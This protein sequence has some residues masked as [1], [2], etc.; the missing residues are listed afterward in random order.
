M[1]LMVCVVQ[2]SMVVQFQGALQD[3]WNRYA[4]HNTSFMPLSLSQGLK[5]PL[6]FSLPSHTL[7][8]VT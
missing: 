4:A 3:D 8:T 1:S 7:I 6:I 5:G 2:V